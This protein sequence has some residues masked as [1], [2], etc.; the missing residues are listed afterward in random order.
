MEKA[1]TLIEL[2]VVIAIVGIIAGLA[3][4]S[5]SGA[6][7]AARI[8]KAKSFSSS[9][10]NSLLGN[11]ISEW[12]FDE[13]AG[14][15]TVDAIGSNNGD[16]TGHAPTWMTEASCVSGKCLQLNGTTYVD[17][18]SDNSLNITDQI[19]VSV[20]VNIDSYGSGSARTAI[21][22]WSSV[23]GGRQ[24][25][26]SV[27]PDKANFYIRRSDDGATIS[28]AGNAVI[29]LNSW[30]NITGV[31]NGSA[32]TMVIY[33]NGTKDN[34][35]SSGVPAAM[36]ST[37]SKLIIGGYN[38]GSSERFSGLIDEVRIYNAALT[39]SVI[40]D[41]YVAGLDK[42]LANGQITEQ[43][44]QQRLTDLNLNYAVNE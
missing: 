7:E 35:L 33:V 44:Y 11:R 29:Q 9:V 10:R 12:K 36:A 43:D 6:T 31:F 32:Q 1:F 20:W 22:K 34:T 39:A 5:M 3:V 14:T 28:L 17:C 19:T 13:G 15:T 41:Q 30:Y 38:S 37:A 27:Y 2:L 42:L 26:L 18:G 8:A 24:Y 23:A 4:V 16:L 21:S 40:R 25:M